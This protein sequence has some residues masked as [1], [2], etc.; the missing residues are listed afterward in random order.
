MFSDVLPLKAIAFQSLFLLI[1]IALEAMVLENRLHL[2]R[3]TSVQYATS[4]NLLSVVI[5]WLVFFLVEPRLPDNLH[6]QLIGYI[7]FDWNNWS[8][9]LTP[10]LIMAGFSVFFITFLIKWLGLDLLEWILGKKTVWFRPQDRH[11][12]Q[13][14]GERREAFQDIPIRPI[15]VLL[16]NVCSFSA[17]SLVLLVRILFQR[18]A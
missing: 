3:K 18:Q 14:R 1:A 10:V 12:N 11:S 15:A 7:F 17:I 5:G 4:I 8:R 13:G 6:T 16:A 9:Q 2:G